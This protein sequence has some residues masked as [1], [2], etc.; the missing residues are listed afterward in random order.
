MKKKFSVEDS[1]VQNMYH[2]SPITQ[3]RV[4]LMQGID[5]LVQASA[6][7]EEL[8]YE[9]FSAALTDLIDKI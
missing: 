7:A 5:H 8:G 9:K 4:N 1:F 3:T 6:L 2:N